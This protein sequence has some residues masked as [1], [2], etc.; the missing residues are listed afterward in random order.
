MTNDLAMNSRQIARTAAV[1]SGNVAR[2]MIVIARRSP[3]FMAAFRQTRDDSATKWGGKRIVGLMFEIGR[4]AWL[5][6]ALWH[7][8]IERVSRVWNGDENVVW[9]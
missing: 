1:S 5:A 8:R 7:R 4:Y 3:A 9:V 6:G 2:R